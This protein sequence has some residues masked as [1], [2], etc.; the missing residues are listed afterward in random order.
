MLECEF[1]NVLVYPTVA[2][3]MDVL[4]LAGLGCPFIASNMSNCI[5][6]A[7][8]E[9]CDLNNYI[10][11]ILHAIQICDLLN[12]FLRGLLRPHTASNMSD[13]I[14]SARFEFCDIENHIIDILHA[15]LL[16]SL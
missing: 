7:N 12:W 3:W 6:G 16:H 1:L 9:F 15:I 14:F 2:R 5:S 13:Y 11:N 8:Y 10:I 4:V